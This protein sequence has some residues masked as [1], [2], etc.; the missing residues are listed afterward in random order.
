MQYNP[1][2]LYERIFR[3]FQENQLQ[4][5][6]IGGVAVNLHGYNRLTGDLDIVILLTDQEIGKFVKVVKEMG[7]V[8]RVPVKIEDFANKEK[9][10]E[11]IE[12]KN[13]LVFSVYNPKNPL[14]H[15]DVKIDESD[16]LE[17]IL[18]NSVAMGDDDLKIPVASIED[19]IKMKE[20]ADRP[21]DRIDV[22]ALRELQK[23]KP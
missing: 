20:K 9:R 19:I 21:R 4:Y 1:G 23:M 8:P 5:A 12:D 17:Q 14:E 3:A 18:K 11:W 2:V 6:V 13:M 7:M 10:R 22:A 15:I 16:S